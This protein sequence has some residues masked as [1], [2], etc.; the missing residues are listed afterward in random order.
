[1]Y[2]Y[3]HMYYIIDMYIYLH[4]SHFNPHNKLVIYIVIISIFEEKEIPITL[5]VSY[6]ECQIP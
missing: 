6:L 5:E 3:K 2:I 4:F 1:M